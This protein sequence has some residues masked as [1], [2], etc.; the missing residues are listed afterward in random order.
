MFLPKNFS[1][2]PRPV[3]KAAFLVAGLVLAAVGSAQVTKQGSGYLLR[4]KYLKGQ[5]LKY[6]TTNSVLGGMNGGQPM[7]IQMPI[8]MKIKDVVKGIAKA[9]VTAGPVNMGGNP[10][11]EAQTLEMDLST[12]N[13]TKSAKGAGL[14]GAQLPIKPVKVG[15]TWS[16]LAPIPD[17][18]GMSKNMKATYKFQGLKTIAGKSMAVL[19]YTLTGGVS[20]SGTLL[21]LASDGTIHSNTAKLKYSGPQGSMNITSEMKRA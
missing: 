2:R 14:T 17:T 21:L 4:V 16:M 11:M 18:T 3:F 1:A 6:S 5:T 7:K 8:V 20:G 12:T 9:Q 19:A 13:Q 10:L 15:Q